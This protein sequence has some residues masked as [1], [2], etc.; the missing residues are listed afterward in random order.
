MQLPVRG[1]GAAFNPPNRF[2]RL[3]YEPD[4]EWVDPDEPDPWR[5]TQYFRD[6]ARSVLT[7][8]T[9]P[10]VP[11]DVGLNPYRG[12]SHGCAYCFA[13]PNHEYLGLSAG[14]EYSPGRWS[15]TDEVVALVVVTQAGSPLPIRSCR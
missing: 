8:N 9:S 1:R 2:E 12:C 13:R 14:L 7:R 4:P 6:S 15:T 5:T 11:F 10:D 3:S